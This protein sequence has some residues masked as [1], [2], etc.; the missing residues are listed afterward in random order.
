VNVLGLDPSL[1]SFGAASVDRAGSVIFTEAFRSK[2]KGMP[3]LLEI[4]A[5]L[6]D[7][8]QAID[9]QMGHQ[10][11]Q[12][13]VM[14][15]YSYAS[16]F[17]AQV[18]GELGFAVKEVLWE[19]EVETL[20]VPPSS[21]KKFV[22]GKGNAQ[23]DEMRLEIFKRFGIEAKTQDELEAAALSVLGWHWIGVGEDNEDGHIPL[24]V[25]KA[26]LEALKKVEVLS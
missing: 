7:L 9:E 20:I 15:G 8:V 1:T 24:L 10:D 18:L 12:L 3:R 6:S 5:W 11:N 14:E 13:A 17:K 16:G 25:P 2:Q 26:H 22:S 23:K 21:L 4:K 19:A